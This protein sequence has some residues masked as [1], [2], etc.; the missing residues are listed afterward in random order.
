MSHAVSEG[1]HLAHG[2]VMLQY[3]SEQILPRAGCLI[4]SKARVESIFRKEYDT[5]TPKHILV[6]QV[7]CIKF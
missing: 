7:F 5:S 2:L 4:D 1:Y 3:S 6:W